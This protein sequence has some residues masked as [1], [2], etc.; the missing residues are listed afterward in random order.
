VHCGMHVAI[1]ETNQISTDMAAVS[2]QCRCLLKQ[3]RTDASH[4]GP[5]I[6]ENTK[7][8]STMRLSLTSSTLSGSGCSPA[9]MACTTL[10]ASCRHRSRMEKHR[11]V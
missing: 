1:Q 10:S 8:Q 5:L 7:T 9:A 2:H 3:P 11:H 6:K 4:R